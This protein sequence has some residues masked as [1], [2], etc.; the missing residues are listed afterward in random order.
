LEGVPDEERRKIIG[1]NVARLYHFDL[2]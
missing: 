2:N 1:A